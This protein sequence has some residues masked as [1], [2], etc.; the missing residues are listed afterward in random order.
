MF[1]YEKN[2]INEVT[3]QVEQSLNVT[4]E[5]NKP[6]E[7]PD[8]VITK[9]GVT[10]I[11]SDSNAY[12]I[13]CEDITGISSFSKDGKKIEAIPQYGNLFYGVNR[14]CSYNITD[15]NP[16]HYPYIYYVNTDNKID[17]AKAATDY[18]INN[19]ESAETGYTGEFTIDFENRTFENPNGKYSFE[20][21]FGIP[22]GSE[23]FGLDLGANA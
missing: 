20:D 4:F 10:G 2:K 13:F 11:K 19:S 14:Y 8:V 5:G 6:V 15:S 12:I 21:V 16:I 3:G 22:A 9:D 1:I 23:V 7:T 17:T 18:F